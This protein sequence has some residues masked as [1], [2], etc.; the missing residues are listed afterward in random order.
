VTAYGDGALSR[1]KSPSKRAIQDC[2]LM[3][4]S[5]TPDGLPASL[6]GVNRDTTG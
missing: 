4:M 3:Q 5:Y 1:Q 2:Q 6:S